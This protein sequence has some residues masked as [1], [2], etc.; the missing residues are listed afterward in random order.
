MSPRL[1]ELFLSSQSDERLVK[2]ARAGHERAFAAIVERYRPELHALARRLCAPGEGEDV[3]QQAL[4]SAFVA[5]RSGAEVQHLRG[6]LY[7]IVRNA[8]IRAHA[9]RSVPLDGATA[10]AETVEEVVQQ[11][12]LAKSALTELARLPERQRRAMVD[13]ALGGLPRAEVASTMGLSEGAVRQLVHR[14]RSTLRT[15]VTAVTPWP[16]ARWLASSGPTAASAGGPAASSG[17]VAAASGG[18]AAASGGV[19]AASSGM[20]AASSG[21]AAASGGIAVK[22]GALIASG[23]LA[24]GVVAIGLHAAPAHH[25]AVREAH[26]THAQSSPRGAPAGAAGSGQEVA[27]I[28]GRS[29]RYA[30]RAVILTASLVVTRRGSATSSGRRGDRSTSTFRSGSPV[31][32]AGGSDRGGGEGSGRGGSGGDGRN[33]PQSGPGDRSGSHGSGSEGSRSDGSRSDESGSDGAGSDGSRSGGSGSQRSGGDG[34]GDAVAYETS[35]QGADSSGATAARQRANSRNSGAGNSDGRSAN[36]NRAGS[37]GGSSN[38]DGVNL[39]AP[40]APSPGG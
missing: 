3:L 25:T 15:V 39:S 6:W 20:A 37:I 9:P 34:G 26:A 38:G 32:F 30:P 5:L 22:L 27:A 36:A 14:A 17:G 16:M 19:A 18:V 12:A 33:E 7:Q 13:T 10:S 35:A 1:P 11:R 28:T 29:S 21:V 2:L 40:G 8:A 31:R 24:T 23:T 4:L